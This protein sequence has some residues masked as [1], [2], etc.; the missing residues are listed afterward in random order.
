MNKT[1]EKKDF[2]FKKVKI[3]KGQVEIEANPSFVIDGSTYSPNLKDKFPMEPHKDLINELSELKKPLAK[4][5][6]LL[7]VEM[8]IES[9]DFKATP[10]QKKAA[11]LHTDVKL[12]QINVTGISLSGKGQNE[13][14]I[15]TGTYGG[16][17]INSKR[18]RFIGNGLG[19]EDEVQEACD[20]V[21]DEVYAYLYQGKITKPEPLEGGDN[22]ADE[23]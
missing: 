5:H 4:L 1:P 15:I 16:Q 19:F 18:I 3:V 14:V 8:L 11:K 17:S 10:A 21:V 6:G 22:I 20:A 13:G 2:G 9:K 7:D 23:G 12:G